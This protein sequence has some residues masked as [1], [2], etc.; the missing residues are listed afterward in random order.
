MARAKSFEVNTFLII[1]CFV[2]LLSVNKTIGQNQY[3]SSDWE[4][5]KSP[6]TL[7]WSSSKLEIAKEYS[8]KIGSSAVM[9]IK[10]GVI[11]DSWG[12]ISTNFQAHSMRKSL[13]TS[14]FGI[15]VYNG[16][17]NLD[18]TLE[19]L[20]IDDN[21]PLTNEEK[22][23]TVKQILESRSGVYLPGL[24]LAGAFEAPPRGSYLPGSN[25]YYNNWDYN[26][27]GT[28]FEQRTHTKIFEEFKK[29]IA[30]PIHMKDFRIE[31][32]YYSYGSH[33]DNVNTRHPEY[34]TR[35]S[36]RDLARFGLLILRRGLWEK[37]QV[38]PSEWIDALVKPVS[39]FTDNS[40][41]GLATWRIYSKGRHLSD[42]GWK[43]PY[44]VY[45]TSGASSHKLYIVSSED[46]IVVHRA[47]TDLPI[48]TPS[49]FEVENLL[50]LILQA[51]I[52]DLGIK[53]D[54][55]WELLLAADKG[56]LNKVKSLLTNGVNVNASDE[57]KQTA[58]HRAAKNGHSAVI[59]IL[60][61][62]GADVH[63]ENLSKET[64]LISSLIR[65][66]SASMKMLIDAGSNI[67]A[68]TDKGQTIL[69]YEAVY[70]RPSIMKMLLDAGAD[71]NLFGTAYHETALMIACVNGDTAVVHQLLDKGA[72]VNAVS[73]NGRNAL[74]I[75]ETLEHKNAAEL[76]K[77]HGAVSN[78]NL[79]LLPLDA[80]LPPRTIHSAM[81]G[82]ISSPIAARAIIGRGKFITAGS[83]MAILFAAMDSDVKRATEL[84]KLGTNV[85]TKHSDGWTP[86]ILAAINGNKEILLQL[87]EHGAQIDDHENIM[88]QTALMWSIERGNTEI[89]LELIKRK[90]S[91]N[92]KDRFGGTPI[93]RA[94][95]NGNAKIVRALIDAGCELNTK[96]DNGNSPINIAVWNGFNE[97]VKILLDAKVN[98]ELCDREGRTAIIIS[99]LNKE[100][101]SLKMLLNSSAN[102]NV[103]DNF[104]TTATEYA[105]IL[106]F[107]KAEQLLAK[108]SLK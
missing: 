105:K 9:I 65:G 36:T 56:D 18:M 106:G 62:K 21:D 35:I 68:R 20:G 91:I 11:L 80:Y 95:N 58:L 81:K 24:A 73:A 90:A 92:F 23:A 4:K 66:D 55:D 69:M 13:L 50:S 71:P 63:S 84:L 88:G 103:K 100:E 8:K 16:D 54:P 31:D 64:P 40:S 59:Q 41:F 76:L 101:E 25:F 28:I 74:L 107:S 53:S 85:N 46:L 45:W 67:N 12:E 79:K 96:E 94:V 27:L 87:I 15:H 99:V 72:N 1:W 86:L 29:Q 57:L 43:L 89:A 77:I 39:H 7:G 44:D 17:I 5:A 70:G 52:S 61:N 49:H 83:D 75:A 108:T 3:P 19:Q 93:S 32:C 38:I 78:A 30:E 47:N 10:N 2:L 82:E 6:E 26:V 34:N 33:T 51:K 102:V 98:T 104:G 48:R 37:Q 97:I 22:Q 42:N 14:M 60:L